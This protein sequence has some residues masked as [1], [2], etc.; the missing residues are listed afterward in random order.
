MSL[1]SPE[2]APEA[3]VS[4]YLGLKLADICLSTTLQPWEALSRVYTPL[5]LQVID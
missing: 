1:F 3:I 2:I 4:P 5:A